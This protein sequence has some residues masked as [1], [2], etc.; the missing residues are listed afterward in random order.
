MSEATN[1]VADKDEPKPNIYGRI[2]NNNLVNCVKKRGTLNDYLTYQSLSKLKKDLEEYRD[3]MDKAA[4]IDISEYTSEIIEGVKVAL[5]DRII[6]MCKC[7]DDILED[8][9]L[10]DLLKVVLRITPLPEVLLYV[11]AK[12]QDF[13][14]NVKDVSGAT[15]FI[16]WITTHD[17]MYKYPPIIQILML[18]SPAVKKLGT[19]KPMYEENMKRLPSLITQEDSRTWMIAITN[20][21]YRAINVEINRLSSSPLEQA[22]REAIQDVKKD[23]KVVN[24]KGGLHALYKIFTSVNEV[25]SFDK[26]LV[27][28]KML[29][30][31]EEKKKENKNEDENEDEYY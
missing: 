27:Y 22:Y 31:L 7:L 20:E 18:T 9:E 10:V 28:Q 12:C 3:L 6:T 21:V 16:D 1:G 17:S 13:E 14:G 30:K 23:L 4:P 15:H 29:K 19:G 11:L 2:L 24:Q 5:A 8:R 26:A 25:Y